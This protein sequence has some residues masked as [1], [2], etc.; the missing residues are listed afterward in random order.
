MEKAMAPEKQCE[1]HEGMIVAVTELRGEVRSVKEAHERMADSVER[2]SDKLGDI[3]R[4]LILWGGLIG[5]GGAILVALI[6]NADK[7]KSLIG[8]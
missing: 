1:R 8:G 7:I 2:I 3:E 6:S 4:K 5:T